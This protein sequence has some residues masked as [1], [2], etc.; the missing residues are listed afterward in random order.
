MAR[1]D[2]AVCDR[3]DN[4]HRDSPHRVGNPALFCAHPA[5]FAPSS[6]K[7]AELPSSFLFI[8][9]FIGLGE[10][11]G[12]RGFALPQLQAKHTPLIASLILAPVWA[13]WHLPLFGNEFAWPIVPPFILSVLGGTCVLTW[14][15]N[16]TK[17]SVL[18]P[19][20]FTQCSTR[21]APG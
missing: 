13:L 17:G 14:I 2:P 9:L 11:P 15:F 18:L 4:S 5:R 19:M 12:W 6:D 3:F 20:Y 8:L 21:S 7:L 16:A 1:W 10:E